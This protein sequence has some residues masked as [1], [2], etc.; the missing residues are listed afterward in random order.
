LSTHLCV[1]IVNLESNKVGRF[2]AVAR[3][4]PEISFLAV[5]GGYG[6]QHVPLLRPSNVEVIDHVSASQMEDQV[7]SRTSVL[8]V[9]SARESWGMTATEAL[10]RGIPV[11]A[12]PTPGLRESLGAAGWFIDRSDIR[13]WCAGLRILTRDP[14][15]YQSASVAAS[16]RG[17]ELVDQSRSQI[18][19]FVAAIEG[20]TQCVKPSSSS[21]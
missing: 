7:W 10:Q 9:P 15:A 5:R 11:L 17:R 3:R 6:T 12:H 14:A 1:T 2:W 13:T 8:L 21:V 20:M 16:R 18:G 19:A 4:L